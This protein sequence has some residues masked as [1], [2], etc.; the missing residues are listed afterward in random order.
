[1]N[2]NTYNETLANSL[3]KKDLKSY[4][5]DVHKQFYNNV[6][7]SFMEYF[8]EI[9]EHEDQFIVNHEKL[10]QYNVITN[11]RSN[12][13]KKCLEQF[14]LVDNIDYLM[15]NVPQQ[16]RQGNVIHKNVYTLTPYA[17]KLCLIRAKN[18]K[19]FANYYLLL[20]R[21]FKFYTN[22]EKLLHK[23]LIS[24]KDEKIDQLE[25]KIDELLK[26]T[27]DILE[28]NEEIKEQNDYLETKV[29]QLDDKV[30]EV[31]ETLRDTLEDRNPRPVYRGEHHHFTLLK[32]KNEDNRYKYIKAQLQYINRNMKTLQ[33]DYDIIINKTYNSNPI[34]MFNRLKATIRSELSDLKDEIT[35]SKVLTIEQKR[36]QR[37]ELRQH[38][39]IK[40]TYSTIVIN[41]NFVSEKDLIAKI[42]ASDSEKY[43]VDIP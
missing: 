26:R 15:R 4:F 41:P 11:N 40:I 31:R 39:P 37:N 3:I 36:E 42:E 10:I 6:D 43:E 30:E 24:M 17:F 5:I 12:D 27:G 13:V 23:K 35:K 32:Y 1:M 25:N 14:N 34:D 20:E 16:C 9:C 21:V 19:R 29:D 2:I 28:I 18:S 38:P 22:Y 8:L 33:K 7:I